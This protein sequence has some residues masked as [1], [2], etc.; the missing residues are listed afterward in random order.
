MTHRLRTRRPDARGFTLIELLVTV[1]IIGILMVVT[2]PSFLRA[3]MSGN[4][5][6]AIASLRT[7]NTAESAYAGV[8]AQG[9]Y[10][11]QLS[12]LTQAC[13][14]GSQGF[15]SLEFVGDPSQKSGYSIALDPGAAA[16]GPPDCNG[17]VTREGYYLTGQPITSGRTGFRSFATSESGV[18]YFNASG[19]PPT[20]PQISGGGA[21]PI[22]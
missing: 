9:R 7:I 20:E 1:A 14:G 17:M 13:P 8:A 19:A 18:I 2:V 21:T 6:S 12:V 11:T 3:K 4:E 22:Q 5:V 10:A 15:L 16:A